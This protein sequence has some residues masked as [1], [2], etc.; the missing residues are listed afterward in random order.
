MSAAFAQA[1]Q[2]AVSTKSR[3]ITGIIP[4]RA[5][6]KTVL[7]LIVQR[8][9]LYK[10]NPPSRSPRQNPRH[11]S[12]RSETQACSDKADAWRDALVLNWAGLKIHILDARRL[13]DT[14]KTNREE[15]YIAIQRLAE[16][17]YHQARRDLK[18]RKNAME[19]LLAELRTPLYLK[20]VARRWSGARAVL[21]KTSRPAALLAAENASNAE[22]QAALDEEKSKYQRA[23][24]DYWKPLIKELRQIKREMAVSRSEPKPH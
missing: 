20:T 6:R 21:R 24:I 19:W 16:R 14:K 12:E 8:Q 13:V 5:Q 4:H 2:P 9:V 11:Q 1:N 15:D 23:N 3:L 10:A 7:C 18:H 22:I 17:V